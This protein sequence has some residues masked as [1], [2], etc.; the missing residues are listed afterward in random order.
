MS[1][2]Q[3]S[4]N[5]QLK[6]TDEFK[7]AKA[8]MEAEAEQM[9]GR[10]AELE[11]VNARLKELEKINAKLEEEKTTTFEIMEGISDDDLLLYIYGGLSNEFDYVIIILTSRNDTVTLTEA[12]Y[13]LQSQELQMEQQLAHSTIDLTMPLLMLLTKV[14]V[15]T[16][17]V[18]ALFRGH[19]IRFNGHYGRTN[20]V[21]GPRDGY[22]GHNNRGRGTPGSGH[23]FSP[24]CQICGRVGHLAFHCYSYFDPN[25]SFTAQND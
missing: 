11:K 2:A 18:L 3:D 22:G 19:N 10:I 14:L 7:A 5:L 24:V 9:K 6:L 20:G 23:G 13:V 15:K 17:V 16:L 25:V 4:K 8:K 12:Q 21:R 1:Y